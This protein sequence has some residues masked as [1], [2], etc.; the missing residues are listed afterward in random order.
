MNESYRR[1][2]NITAKVYAVIVFLLGLAFAIFAYLLLYV[3]HVSEAAP[4]PLIP[5][6]VLVVSSIFIW[7]GATWAMILVVA[8]ALGFVFIA[9][10]DPNFVALLAVPAVFAA[11]TATYIGCRAKSSAA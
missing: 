11:L 7:R 3:T 5:A 1:I 4:F 9:R 6:S 10:E 8:L 2:A